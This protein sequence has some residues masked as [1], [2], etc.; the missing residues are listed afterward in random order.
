MIYAL[1]MGQGSRMAVFYR[2]SR[3]NSSRKVM[4]NQSSICRRTMYVRATREFQNIWAKKQLCPPTRSPKVWWEKLN[5]YWDFCERGERGWARWKGCPPG[6]GTL[7]RDLSLTR[8]GRVVF[9][10]SL[11]ERMWLH[12]CV[13]LGQKA[14]LRNRRV[15][16][17]MELL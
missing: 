9:K 12:Q 8:T 16:V 14:N 15:G 11:V 6:A 10:D 17:L 1:L 13:G 3:K 7:V 5:F 2:E 4:G